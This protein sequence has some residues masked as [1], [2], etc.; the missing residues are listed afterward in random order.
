MFGF[1]FENLNWM[2]PNVPPI[3]WWLDSITLILSGVAAF[4]NLRASR[5]SFVEVRRVYLYTGLL[6]AFYCVAYVWLLFSSIPIGRWS[7]WM[8]PVAI[9]TWP[10]VWIWPACRAT[11]LAMK[12]QKRVGNIVD[13]REPNGAGVVHG[14]DVENDDDEGG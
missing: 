10:I 1:E 13:G 5:R 7:A 12:V 6:A 11:K 8:N 14:R 2:N 9:L 3:N 4:V